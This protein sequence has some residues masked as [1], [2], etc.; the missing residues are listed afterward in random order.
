M[1]S[2]GISVLTESRT[3]SA[4]AF[5]SGARLAG[6]GFWLLRTSLVTLLSEVVTLARAL[7]GFAHGEIKSRYVGFLM[8]LKG[9][10]F[11]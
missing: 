1:A 3:V 11:G 8:T 2:L 6:R 5:C 7:R 4:I 9:I 10:V